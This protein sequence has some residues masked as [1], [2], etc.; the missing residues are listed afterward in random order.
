MATTKSTSRRTLTR[1][2]SKPRTS[3]AGY[4]V[5]IDVGGTLT[6]LV[7]VRPDRSIQLDKT[8]TTPHDQSEV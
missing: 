7:L 2:N 3:S 4:R 1:L 8:A 6:D 5:G